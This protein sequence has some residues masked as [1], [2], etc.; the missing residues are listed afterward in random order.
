MMVRADSAH[1]ALPK[2]A[3]S[4]CWHNHS[5]S[6]V[7]VVAGDHTPEVSRIAQ[8]LT[9]C[10]LAITSSAAGAFSGLGSMGGLRAAQQG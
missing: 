7:T 8:R 4:V 6:C 1:A 10:S 3:L 2:V 9:D 5:E